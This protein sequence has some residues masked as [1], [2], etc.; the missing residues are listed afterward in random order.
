MTTPEGDWQV[1]CGQER[2]E[3]CQKDEKFAYIV[4]LGRAVNSQT[5]FTLPCFARALEILPTRGVPA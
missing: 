4:A 2:F 5:S 1:A 3:E